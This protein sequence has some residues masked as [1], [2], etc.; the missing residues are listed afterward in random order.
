MTI[1]RFAPTHAIVLL[2]VLA[3]AAC[4]DGSVAGPSGSPAPVAASSSSLSE[5]QLT[6]AS[7]I[8]L[9]ETGEAPASTGSALSPHPMFSSILPELQGGTKLPVLLPSSVP[10]ADGEPQVYAILEG[11]SPS[12]YSTILGFTADCNGGNACRLGQIA[13]DASAL[14][15]PVGAEAVDLDRGI[16][17]YFV[18]AT[19]GA[20][21]S[22]AQLLWE[23]EGASYTIG[24]KAGQKRSLIEMANSAIATAQ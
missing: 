9:S 1:F 20:N 13:A 17:G 2:S 21:C 12:Q 5:Q 8:A 14:N 6:E 23:Y 3:L 24:L 11:V 22:D 18:P 15:V 10:Q 16:S 4:Q 19:C 7:A